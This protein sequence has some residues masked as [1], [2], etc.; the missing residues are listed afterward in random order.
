[1]AY[2]R[3][4]LPHR[5]RE[6]L[7]RLVEK[8]VESMVIEM[9]IR[10]QKWMFMC[11]Y[12]PNV[13]FKYQCCRSIDSILN[14]IQNDRVSVSHVLGDLSINLL[15]PRE[16]QCIRD[17]VE[18]HGLENMISDP[19]C[20]KSDKGSLLDVIFTNAKNRVS[21]SLNI[22]NGISDFHNITCFST[23]LHVPRPIKQRIVYRTYKNFNED[24]FKNDIST[25]PYHVG[26][27]FE[28]FDD[29]FWFYK[30]LIADITDSHA[31]IKHRQPVSFPVPFM[32]SKLRKA[33]HTKSMLR[34]RYFRGGRTKGQWESYRKSR[35]AAT[36]LKAESMKKYF[37]DKCN[38]M[39]STVKQNVF[40]DSIKPFMTEKVKHDNKSICLKID[41]SI[42][43]RPAA[44]CNAFN[45]YLSSIA[46]SL[47]NN[48]DALKEF[49]DIECI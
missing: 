12:N 1:M 36:K 48:D 26:E 24:T 6:D 45:D 15:C 35:N 46:S 5:R 31:P 11:L 3:C 21:S 27:I 19:T 41:D 22:D 18:T 32:N 47:G 13:N 44:V 28:D 33:C 40:W 9:I 43:S 39:Y 30:K 10:R 34:N 20:F 49:E 23:M 2:I 42:I 37:E 7:E 14:V 25:A 8:P 4:D 16:S 38:P 17:V 29:K